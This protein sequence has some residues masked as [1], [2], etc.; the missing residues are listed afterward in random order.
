MRILQNSG[1]GAQL[2]P[3]LGCVRNLPLP[4]LVAIDRKLLLEG[5]TYW[6]QQPSDLSAA[7]PCCGFRT[8]LRTL[9]LAADSVHCWGLCTLLRP[10]YPLTGSV[11]CCGLCTLP[12]PLYLAAG[13]V[14]CSGLCTLLCL[15]FMGT[16]AL[17]NIIPVL[18]LLVGSS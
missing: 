17:G 7:V 4:N 1:E 14:P 9:D 5:V 18:R 8:L 10:L 15:A 13:C 11:R 6:G 12:R 16:V 3:P 2:P